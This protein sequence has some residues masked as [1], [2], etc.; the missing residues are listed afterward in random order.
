[1]VQTAENSNSSEAG[2]GE[3]KKWRRTTNMV[4][5]PGSRG[6]R[7]SAEEK[8]GQQVPVLPRRWARGRGTGALGED[9]LVE[10]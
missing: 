3:E 1:M 4:Q 8:E 10:A 5:C 9:G 2:R 6:K 7:E